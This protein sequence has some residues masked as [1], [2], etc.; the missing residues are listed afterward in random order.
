MEDQNNF[1]NTPQNT[2]QNYN[3]RDKIET[4]GDWI[5]TFLISAIPI[6]GIIMIFIWAFGK[7]ASTTKSNWA[8]AVLIWVAIIL[9]IEILIFSSMIGTFMQLFNNM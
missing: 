1:Q 2:P 4:V 6:A 8:K 5:I 3:P 9:A 7:D